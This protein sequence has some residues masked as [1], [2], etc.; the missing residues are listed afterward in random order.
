MSDIVKKLEH[1]ILARSALTARRTTVEHDNEI[2]RA[3]MGEIAILRARNDDLNAKAME[4]QAL[5]DKQAAEIGF[6]RDALASGIEAREGQDAQR[7]GAQH[8]SPARRETPIPAPSE[9][10]IAEIRAEVN[11]HCT[12][13]AL[14]QHC[15]DLLAALDAA[16]LQVAALDMEGQ[17]WRSRALSAEAERDRLQ[18]HIEGVAKD[19]HAIMSRYEAERDRLRKERDEMEIR[20]RRTIT[21]AEAADEIRRLLTQ[22]DALAGWLD[23]ALN[24]L[25]GYYLQEYGSDHPYHQRKLA[26]ER[27]SW[28]VARGMLATLGTPARDDAALATLQ[29]LGQEFDAEEKRDG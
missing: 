26:E 20:F 16:K 3:A 28:I 23:E 2:D 29:R 10:R 22:R 13:P 11:G 1:R 27:G 9:A 5:C 18:S 21:M 7:L 15:L 19:T 8:E 14:R 6:L 17:T 4:L 24:E 25:D 12:A